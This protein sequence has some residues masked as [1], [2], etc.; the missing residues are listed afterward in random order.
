M[1]IN[2][3]VGCCCC[4]RVELSEI[5]ELERIVA[6]NGVV[7]AFTIF[8]YLWRQIRFKIHLYM[9]E[10]RLVSNKFV[11]DQKLASCEAHVNQYLILNRLS[12]VQI[13]H[14]AKRRAGI[15]SNLCIRIT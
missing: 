11:S 5:A 14:D 13:I 1:V 12:F 8:R 9:Y 7:D 2:L 4:S 3:A 6:A 15:W 10:S